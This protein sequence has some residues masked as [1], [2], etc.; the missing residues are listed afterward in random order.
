M[1]QSR[2][3]NR[4]TEFFRCLLPGAYCLL[5][6]C[7]LPAVL[8]GQGVAGPVQGG[9]NY[10]GLEGSFGLPSVAWAA[11]GLTLNYTA[12]A[13]FQKGS[14]NAITGG[15]ATLTTTET[16]CSQAGILAGACNIVYWPG[17]GSSLL[18]TTAY[19][20]AAASGN[21]ILYFCTTNSGANITGCAI[22]TEDVL[23][24]IPATYNDGLLMVPVSNCA[25]TA[26]TTAFT[27]S[28]LTRLAANQIAW[29]GTTNTTAGTVAMT[30]DL[31]LEG[32]TTSGL[33]FVAKDIAVQ[34][35]VQ[36]TALA[37]IATPTLKTNGYPA[38][39]GTAAD[40]LTTVGGTLTSNPAS[41]QL[42]LTTSGTFYNADFS[43]GTPFTLTD[44]TKVS[45]E[46]VFTTAGSTATTIQ[47]SG[48]LV[49]GNWIQ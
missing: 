7:L 41:L 45:F 27:A 49:H 38:Y 3:G 8:L 22:A 40:T 46:M 39:G 24:A 35:G 12:G 21:E 18:A 23:G 34:Y 1:V 44:Q 37:S 9:T 29:S 42:A 47:V 20:T 13:V 2:I 15:T 43:V 17:S 14:S 4:Q 25:F 6:L 31:G 32:R 33:G 28:G 36:T 11:T 19:P 26:T 10:S 30:C 5:F 16:S 48:L